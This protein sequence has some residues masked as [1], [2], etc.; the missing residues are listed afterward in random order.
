MDRLRG[1]CPCP[2]RGA[3]NK[4]DAQF[5]MSAGFLR[6]FSNDFIAQCRRHSPAARAGAGLTRYAHDAR[7]ALEPDIQDRPFLDGIWMPCTWAILLTSDA[8]EPQRRRVRKHL[9]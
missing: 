3:Y 5:R 2:Q 6:H 9:R 8:R 1:F 4:G 7:P